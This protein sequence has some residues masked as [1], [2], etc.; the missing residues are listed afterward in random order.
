MI[1]DLAKN[2][3]HCKQGPLTRELLR[4]PG[5]FGLGQLPVRKQPDAIA[6]STCGFCGTGCGLN[7][8]LKDGEAVSLSPR[9]EYPVNLGMA[10]PKGWEALTVLDSGDRATTPLLRD[11]TGKLTPVDWE[12]AATTFVD[13]FKSIQKQYGN[14]AVAFLGSGQL[15]NEE[16]AFLGALAKFGMGFVHGDGNTRQCMASAVTA[17]K[18]SFGFDAPGYT[19][20]DY[21][22][23]DVIVFIG[24]NPCI[25]HPIMW[26]RVAR[27]RNDP[28]IVVI[29][30]RLTETA[31]QADLHLQIRPK[32][33][34]SLFYGISRLLIE[35]GW[36]DRDFIDSHT[37][38]FENYQHF[39]Q[40]FSLQRTAEESGL[41]PQLIKDLTRIIA[42]GEAVSFY[43]T[44]GVNQ[45]YQGTRTAQAIINLALMTGNIGRPGTGP[46]SIT[47]QCNAMGSRL[48]SNTSSLL[49]G[50]DFTRKEDRQEVA[51]ILAV[52]ERAIPSVNSWPYHKIMDGIL[53]GKIRGL[54]I[55]CTN[56]VHSWINQNQSRDILERLDFLVVQDMYHNTDSAKMADLVLP[57]AGWGEKQGTFI[58]SER[59][60][61]TIKKVAK[62][63]GQALSDF[64]IFKLLAHYWGCE[65]M[66]QQWAT[67]ESVFQILKR[68]T[69]G[70]PCDITGIE[71]YNMLDEMEGIQWPCA[72]LGSSYAVR[73]RLLESNQRRLYEEGR[74]YHSDGRAK[75]LFEEPRPLSE[76]T[77]EK[78][79]FIL[80]TGRG[81]AAQ[82]H[83]QTRTKN[84]AVLRKLYPGDPFVEINPVD[85]Q[86]REI[87]MNDWVFVKSQRGKM[88]A[89]AFLTHSVQP[90]QVFIP[91]HYK[92]TNNLTDAVFDPDS[93]QPSF[94]ACAVTVFRA[95]VY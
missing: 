32:G 43:W 46:N 39:V 35:N 1:S 47:G 3:L 93:H 60:I 72:D 30:P 33:D 95:G 27:N 49:G 82:W 81:T 63:P 40:D 77:S 17:Y 91:M 15:P 41:A 78:Y 57:A 68:L 74:F 25:A 75:F 21:E 53:C 79:P 52:D 34:L 86:K 67:P 88:K 7:I 9:T 66:F 92:Q 36:I 18:Q 56:P 12:T 8:H 11:L 62:A 22:E 6:A 87:S 80:L 20:Q 85:A 42:G 65:E 44:M 29:D 61:N 5:R 70:Q 19:Y 69:K 64:S 26:E 54:W 2:L 94:K 59:R 10:C 45:S 73:D 55:V 38:R 50:R 48:F 83:T 37:N 14:E 28:T 24:A 84:S 31:M 76:P 90:G 51:D 23:S 13:R 4:S 71:D 89:T 16:L 58:N